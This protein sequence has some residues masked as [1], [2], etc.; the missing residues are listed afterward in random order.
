M[1]MTAYQVVLSVLS[2]MCL[3]TVR[4]ALGRCAT[5]PERYACDSAVRHLCTLPLACPPEA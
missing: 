4:R 3:G 2:C 1:C 5:A